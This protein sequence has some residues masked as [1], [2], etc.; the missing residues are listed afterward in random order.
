M[1]GD[2]MTGYETTREQNDRDEVLYF[3]LVPLPN[4]ADQSYTVNV[5]LYLSFVAPLSP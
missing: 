2:K 4:I 5:L 3:V 1:T